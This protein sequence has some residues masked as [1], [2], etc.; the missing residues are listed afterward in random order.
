MSHQAIEYDQTGEP[1]LGVRCDC[2]IGAD[3]D[4]LTHHWDAQPGDERRIAEHLERQRGLDPSQV[5][6]DDG[7][8]AQVGEDAEGER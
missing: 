8:I 7:R 3:H 6:L 4:R 5:R 2:S 1:L